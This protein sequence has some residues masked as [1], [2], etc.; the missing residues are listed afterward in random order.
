MNNFDYEKTKKYIIVTALFLVCIVSA[1]FVII[2]LGE[3]SSARKSNERVEEVAAEPV[4]DSKP[5]SRVV[6]HNGY[7]GNS[8]DSLNNEIHTDVNGN[9]YQVDYVEENVDTFEFPSINFQS[10]RNVNN[11]L[12]CWLYIPTIDLSYPVVRSSDNQDYLNTNFEGGKSIAGTLFTD[13]RCSTPF[14]QK[15]IIYGHNMKDGSMFNKL[16]DLESMVAD[17]PKIYVMFDGN[18]Y[19]E[20]VVERVFYTVNTDDIYSIN[21][22]DDMDTLILST[23]VKKEK[24]FVVIAHRVSAL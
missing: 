3:Y 15:T 13:C 12:E 10:L 20:Y 11:N 2:A 24:R 18:K 22:V 4:T 6:V 9:T 23:C 7:V 17:S 5:P 19:M 14:Y 21:S 16:Y 8:D 1:I